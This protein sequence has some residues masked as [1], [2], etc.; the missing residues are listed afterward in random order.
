M[1]LRGRWR[2]RDLDHLDDAGHLERLLRVVGCDLAAVHRRARDHGEQHAIEQR[3][4]AVGGAAAD[5]IRTVDKPHFAL[6]DVAELLG[7]LEA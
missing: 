4:D 1:E 2:T 7:F 5:D 6:A 3:I